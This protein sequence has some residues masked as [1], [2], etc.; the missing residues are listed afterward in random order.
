MR[1][2][3]T[4][5]TMTKASENGLASA[6]LRPSSRYS[7]TTTSGSA[8][9]WMRT[10]TARVYRRAASPAVT[11]ARNSSLVS[12]R[13]LRREPGRERHLDDESLGVAVGHVP[14]RPG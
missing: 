1:P 11:R 13:A 4:V 5:T 14:R 9:S 3:R 12:L 6:P 10:S 7:A 2:S 8:V